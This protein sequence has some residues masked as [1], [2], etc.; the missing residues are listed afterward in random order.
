MSYL[1]EFQGP[2]V[3]VASRSQSH[4][5]FFSLDYATP[6]FLSSLGACVHLCFATERERERERS[7]ESE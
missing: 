7:F 1:F 4:K 5:S 6:K 3:V 2:F